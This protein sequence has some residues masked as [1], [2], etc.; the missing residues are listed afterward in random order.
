MSSL[1]VLIEIYMLILL[2]LRE[3]EQQAE[4]SQILD[5]IKYLGAQGQLDGEDGEQETA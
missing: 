3:Q 5:A 4:R 2:Q 1:F